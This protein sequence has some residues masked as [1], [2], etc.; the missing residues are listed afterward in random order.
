MLLLAWTATHLLFF[1]DPRFH[2]PI[3]F[4]CAI[5]AARGTVAAFEA[6]LRPLPGLRRKGY[7][8]A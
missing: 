1:G 5:L 7:A 3:V 6:L 2:Y 4:A 8:T